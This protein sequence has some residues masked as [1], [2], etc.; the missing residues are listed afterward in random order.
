MRITNNIIQRNSL[1]ALQVNGRQMAQAQRRVS[2]G[3]RIEVASDDPIAANSVMEA[4]QSLRALTQYRRNVDG[5]RSRAEAEESS[6]DRL[7]DVLSRALEVAVTQADASAD[8]STRVMAANEIDQ[9]MKQAVQ[10]GNTQFGGRFLFGGFGA[11]TAPIDVD[12][13]GNV[14]IS[15]SAV[16][17]P[18]VEL[19]MGLRLRANH[20]ATE[21][22]GSTGVFSA[23][24]ALKSGLQAADQSAISASIDDL[25]DAVGG[26]QAN[27]GE[28]GAWA[29]QLNV[30]AANLDAFE[31]NLTT[32]K[33]ELSE[34]DLEKA[35]TDLVS[36]QNSYQAA[37]LATSR[38][39]GM[40]LADY[41]R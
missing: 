35:V 26:V 28:L 22:F 41:L 2:S 36:R 38:V 30:T 24:D 39:M 37:M 18:E 33:A 27:V 15:A 20:N 3:M 12:G 19:S 14:S 5:A 32:F 25:R 29:S 8:P 11:D 21:V 34:V 10:I 7:T 1:A 23:L 16:G 13:L 6:L 17:Q 4:Q 31:V 40:T 9:L